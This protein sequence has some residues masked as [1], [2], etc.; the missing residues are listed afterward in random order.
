MFQTHRHAWQTPDIERHG[1]V[2]EVGCVDCLAIDHK[3]F[4]ATLLG[5]AITQPLAGPFGVDVVIQEASG[6]DSIVFATL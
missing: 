4:D 3:F 5:I 6:R 1:S 2:L